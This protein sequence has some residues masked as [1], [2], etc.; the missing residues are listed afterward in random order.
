MI[1]CDSV[2]KSDPNKK[3]EERRNRE[4]SKLVMDF[5]GPQYGVDEFLPATGTPFWQARVPSGLAPDEPCRVAHG[6][7]L[8]G[9]VAL[10]SGERVHEVALANSMHTHIGTLIATSALGVLDHRRRLGGLG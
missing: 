6:F 7:E 2:L 5:T 1:L 4:V 9:G 10:F 8:V 3:Y